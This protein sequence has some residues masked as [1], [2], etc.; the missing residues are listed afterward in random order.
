MYDGRHSPVHAG[1]GPALRP[2]HPRVV[3]RPHLIGDVGGIA[4]I[5]GGGVSTAAGAGP[6]TG[7]L[8]GNFLSSL[9]GGSARDKQRQARTAWTLSEANQGSPLAAA[10]I[11]AAPANV[12]NDEAPFWTA[13]LSQV[14]QDILNAANAKYPN[15][16][17]PVNQP[18]FYTDQNGPTHRAIVAEVQQAG[19]IPTPVTST[20]SSSGSLIATPSYYPTPATAGYPYASAGLSSSLL[21]GK[22][23]A[24]GAAALA[25]GYALTRPQARRR[26]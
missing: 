24:I 8:A 9:F 20:S 14:R 17:W 7:A 26:R 25:I 6:V 16:Y 5:L 18:D 1:V 10:V 2:Y 22:T 19:G 13:A 11:V 4:A 15:G 23:L 12:A 21:N 3:S